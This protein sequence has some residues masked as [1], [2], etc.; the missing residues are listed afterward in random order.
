MSASPRLVSVVV[1]TR[2]R[3]AFLRQALASIRA[4]EGPDLSFEI[5]VGDNGSSAETAE[6]A[7]AFAARY[8]KVARDGAG[9]ARNAGLEAASGDYVAF[10]DDDDVWLPGN[11]RAQLALLDARPELEGVVGQVVCTDQA[12]TPNMAPWPAEHPGE[13]DELVLTMLS[14][15]YP[16]I[17]ATMV[18]AAAA[19]AIGAFDENLLGDQDWDW[20]L[21]LARRRKLGYVAEQ[22]VLFRQRAAGTFDQ[23]RQARLG[24]TRR[25]F[26]RHAL[27]EWRTW[28]SLGRFARAYRGAL[29]QYYVYF[30]EAAVER[31]QSGDRRAAQRAIVGAFRVFPLRAGFHVIAPRPLRTAFAWAFLGAGG[32]A[33]AA[34]SD[35]S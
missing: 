26:F 2:D 15:Y 29:W 25:V 14:G 21:R 34:M 10:L 11:V 31:V 3:P 5:L 17:G 20:Q 16:Q 22:C 13:G 6:V 24:F 28:T 33:A 8:L 23:L 35:Q 30:T 18:R 32:G 7:A 9:A 4:L 12:L 27:A 19:R 1:P